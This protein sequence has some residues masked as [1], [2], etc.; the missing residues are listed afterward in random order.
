M[1]W[2]FESEKA[3][4]QKKR[5]AEANK[6]VGKP[7]VGGAFNLIDQD[8]KPFTDADLKGQYSLVSQSDNITTNITTWPG[9]N[10]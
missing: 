2:Y 8:G 7:R 1:A 4:M 6:S 3:R 10:S 5:I 9:H